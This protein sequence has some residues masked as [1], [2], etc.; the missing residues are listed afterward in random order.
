[1]Q[2]TGQ[3]E[4]QARHDLVRKVIHNLTLQPNGIC[5][6]QYPSKKMRY[7]KLSG[8]WIYKWILVLI[9]SSMDASSCMDR[10]I[11]K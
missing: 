9:S 1:M 8:T 11:Y 3:K 5:T 2:Q 7:I 6:T 10:N 4:Y